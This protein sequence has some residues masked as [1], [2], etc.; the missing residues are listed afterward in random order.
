[1]MQIR[2]L[3]Y[4][5]YYM[6]NTNATSTVCELRACSNFSDYRRV[7]S[8]PGAGAPSEGQ[9]YSYDV[10]AA[11]VVVYSTEFYYFVGYGWEQIERQYQWLRRDLA[12]ANRSENRA[13]RPWIIGVRVTP[14]RLS[15]SV[16]T[17][18]NPIS[19]VRVISTV[20]ITIHF[21]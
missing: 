12:E 21:S 13:R 14:D 3:L 18:I 1:M 16:N 11:H 10:G 5:S 7:V 9:Y 15:S 4:Y 8:M 17:T 19:T 20:Y 2:V 6:F